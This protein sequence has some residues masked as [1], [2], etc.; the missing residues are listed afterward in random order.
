MA[1]WKNALLEIEGSLV[2]ASLEALS[3]VL[4]QDTLSS[5]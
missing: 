2:R 1:Q 5:A 4:E 3:C